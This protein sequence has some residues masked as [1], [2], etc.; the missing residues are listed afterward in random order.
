MVTWGGVAG[1]TLGY[2]VGDVPGAT[3]G[4]EVGE[5]L[6]QKGRKKMV[7]GSANPI[8]GSAPGTTTGSAKRSRSVSRGRSGGSRMRTGSRSR[9]RPVSRQYGSR[10]RSRS[11]S[12]A[13]SRSK[14]GNL[15]DVNVKKKGKK[16]AKEGRKKTVKVPKKLRKQI[17][18]V[19]DG[20]D[21]IGIWEEVRMEAFVIP[22]DNQQVVSSRGLSSG[23]NQILFDPINVIYAASVLWLKKAPSETKTLND[24]GLFDAT[25]FKVELLDSWVRFNYRNNTGRVITMKLYDV[26]LKHQIPRATTGGAVVYVG[27]VGNWI[28][29]LA[30]EASSAA[31]DNSFQNANGITINTLYSTPKMVTAFNHMYTLDCTTVSLEPGKEYMHMVRG[32]KNKF[33]DYAKF[34]N[35]TT[36]VVGTETFINPQKFTKEHFVVAYT[37]LTG[38]AV[39][40]GLMGR[41]MGIQNA[42]AGFGLLCES[43]YFYKLRLPEQAGATVTTPAAGT[44]SNVQLGHRTYRYGIVNYQ[45]PVSS[46]ASPVAY[47]G[48]ENPQSAGAAGD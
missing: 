9:S 25:T 4:Y 21:P 19:I 38:I 18:K 40:N 16:V 33:Y 15:D 46:G 11:R 41:Y 20:D 31:G 14:A 32:P 5:Y 26:S 1:G 27:A 6:S 34:L 48:D 23:G 2:I 22:P 35:G 39:T 42:D 7:Y 10:S 24:V 8:Y 3:V 47:I 28:N 13:S 30:Q 12:R 44:V 29:M 17:K 45:E 36:N 43:R 37:D